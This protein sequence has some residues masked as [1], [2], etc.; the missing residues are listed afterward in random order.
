MLSCNHDLCVKCAA[1][2]L[3]SQT[4]KSTT[5]KIYLQCESCKKRTILDEESV[6]ELKKVMKRSK[7]PMSQSEKE[8]VGT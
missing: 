7:S 6:K 2:R 4:L 8:K 5:N 1:V 3:A